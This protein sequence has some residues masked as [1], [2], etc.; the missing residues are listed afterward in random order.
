MRNTPLA[1]LALA[2]SLVSALAAGELKVDI[3]RDGK[4]SA[5]T[6]ATGYAQWTTASTGGTA[7]TGTAPITQSFPLAATGET[8]VVSLAMTA[9]AQ[10]AGGSGITYTYYATGT[11]TEG[12]KLVSDGVTV[13]PAVGN[14]GGQL[15]MTLTGLNPGPHSLLT[16]HNAGDAASALGTLAPIKVYLNGSY[17][18]TFTPSIRSTD[19]AA[20]TVYLSFTTASTGDVTTILFAADTDAA[21]TTKNVV[22]N[23]FEIDTPNSARIANTPSPID[24]DEHVD[25]DSGEVTL[26]WA[27]ALAG[28]TAS[29][30]VYLGTGLAAV[31]AATRASPQYLGNQVANS[32]SVPVADPF[33][34]YYWRIDEV[35]TLGNVTAGAVWCFRPRHLAFPG[36]EG[37]GRF[38]RGGRGGKVVHVTSLDDYTGD[39]T[40]IPGTLRHA[41]TVETGPR[42]I[43]FD[44]GGLIT[45]KS[46]LTLNSPYVTIAGQTA[47]GK[48]V[49]LKTWT[50]GLS[51][52]ND[53]V[54][55]FLRSRPGRTLQTITVDRYKN[56][57]TGTPTTATA[58]VAVDGMG[59]QGSSHAIIDHC[60]ISWTIDEAFSSR[61]AKNITLQRTLISEA[62]N[63]ALHPNY[64]FL[65]DLAGSEHG[66]AASVG[67][68]VGSFH[69]NLLAHCYGRNWS[70]AGGL[71][72]SATFAGRLDFTNNVVYNWGSRTTDGGAM[73]V[74]FTGNYY[75]PGAGT[76][77][78]PY[79]LTM[80][81]ENDFAGS[82]RCYFAG[83]V[84]PGHFD[85]SN[86]TVGRRSVVS[87]GVPAPTYETFVS[88]PFFPSYVT[89]QTALGAYKRVLSDVGANVPLDDHDKRVINETLAGTYTYT[90]SVTG[91]KGF[92]DVETDV[93]GW[94][95]YPTEYRAPGWDSD[96]DGLP[97]WWET[98][99]GTNPASP[100][101]DFSEANASPDGD[102]YT[103]LDDYLA[104]MALPRVD[105]ASGS[106]VDIDLSALTRG[107]TASPSRQ[108]AL[109]LADYPAGA[110]QLLGDGKTARFT[111]APGFTGVARFQH[112]VTDA[113]GDSMSGEV[114]VRVVAVETAATLQIAQSDG[115]LFLDFTGTAGQT[116]TI[117]HSPD[118]S[119]WMNLQDLVATGATQRIPVPPE[120]YPAPRRFFRAI[121]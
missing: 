101:G 105:V 97:D 67:G 115:G 99:H 75:K 46:R 85:E 69:H 47:P 51:G 38:A 40:P 26:S 31:K 21:A 73:E 93:G 106:S 111:A 36:A 88:T 83:N 8:V 66:Y 58:A 65:D 30:D 96:A 108:V 6:T 117:Q 50:M 13:A 100:A 109:A 70:M 84:M 28:T 87:G 103:R 14:A 90:G 34:T 27:S 42:V 77:L 59:M 107:Y 80:N 82:Q 98:L 11:T 102:G 20:P 60:S 71:D 41:V 16:F 24:A 76:T 81:H 113:Q 2:L 33:A 63:K 57:A 54:I 18:T 64:I 86:Q 74:N 78:V 44:V 23:G 22:L 119:D 25:A 114:G 121:R 1:R 29:H 72:A 39:E 62:L 5:S 95:D 68:D 19:I 89:T 56:G 9:A 79:A 92:P 112:T 12:Q 48:G 55:R 37:Y 10:S 116:F 35:D 52:A 32:R 7:S 104:W 45:L 43:V 49:C 118:L 17:V 91:K 94:E 53:A 3:N 15:Q 4:N 110:V 61:S 120:L